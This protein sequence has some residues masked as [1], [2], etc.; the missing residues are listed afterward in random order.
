M[1]CVDAAVQ[2]VAAVRSDWPSLSVVAA[3]R[4]EERWR[5]K[6]SDSVGTWAESVPCQ[7]GEIPQ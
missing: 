6:L 3:R 7:R 2:G 1:W 5:F 4:Q